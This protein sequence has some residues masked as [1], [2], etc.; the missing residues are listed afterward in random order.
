LDSFL[1]I[2]TNVIGFLVLVALMAAIGSQNMSVLLGTPIVR[3]PPAGATRVLFECRH[4]RILRIDE[5]KIN[6]SIHECL[7]QRGPAGDSKLG[8]SEIPALLQQADAGDVSYRVRAEVRRDGT[9][10]NEPKLDLIYEPRAAQQGESIEASRQAASAY[11]KC[12]RSL[13]AK[14]HFAY[15]I[16]RQDSFEVFREARKIARDHGLAIG[17]APQPLAEELRFTE[18]GN[19]GKDVQD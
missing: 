14:K 3:A 7:R 6:Q 5:D 13:D 11:V 10:A 2:V 16:V 12:V 18:D 15:F 19:F 4:N 17:W 9:S 1:D 8:I